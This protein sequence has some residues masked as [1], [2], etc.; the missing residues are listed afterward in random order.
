MTSIDM[1]KR[2]VSFYNRLKKSD[3]ICSIGFGFNFDD[4]HINGI[5]R[6]LIDKDDKSLYIVDV[7]SEKNEDDKRKDYAKRLKVINS[8][9]IKFVTVDRENRKVRNRLW[10]DI[11]PGLE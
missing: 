4:E 10:V 5:I 1:A 3:F 9:K 2:Y 6:T 7:E 11:L 8:N